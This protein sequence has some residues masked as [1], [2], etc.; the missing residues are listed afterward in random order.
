[1]F[2]RDYWYVAAWS[3]QVG[4]EPLARTI[5]DEKVVLFRKEDGTAVA[6]EDRCAH[7]R[8]PLSVGTV[9]GDTLQCG[10]HGL[11]YDCAGQCIKVPGQD[12]KPNA[13]VR[14]FPLIE[15]DQYV[16]IWLGDP[17]HADA[18]KMIS[19]PHLGDPDWVFFKGH[20][21]VQANYLLIFDNLLDLSHLAYVHNSTIG[22]TPVAENAEVK[23]ERVGNK[24]RVTRE[25]VDVPAAQLYAQFGPYRGRFDRWQLS[26][27]TPPAYFLVNNGCAAAN[28]G[29]G[30]D[31][32][33][34]TPGEW[35]FQVYH[36]ITPATEKS[37]H[38]FWAI[39]YH[40]DVVKEEADRLK[41]SQQHRGVI[42]EDVVIYNAQQRALDSDLRGASPQDVQSTAIIDAD[43][44]LYHARRIV[45]ALLAQNQPVQE[46]A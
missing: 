38:Q 2:L 21:E 34:D 3:D 41:F 28:S 12:G 11:V 5:L 32:R 42:G 37:T 43:T 33:I 22:N 7:R 25:M 31:G 15:R 24:V 14:S 29:G 9:I 23:T 17:E 20:V 10:Y 36:C 13:R 40:K 26:E 8:L 30:D 46:H 35:G 44:G 18:S 39:A 1:M 16:S 27:Y 19:R 6:L 45:Q 4:R